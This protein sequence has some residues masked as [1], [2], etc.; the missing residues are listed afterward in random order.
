MLSPKMKVSR[1]IYWVLIYLFH[2]YLFI[3]C[4]NEFRLYLSL[5]QYF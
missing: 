1:K 5:R 3:I 4:S 2:I